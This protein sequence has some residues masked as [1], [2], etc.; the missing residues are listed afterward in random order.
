MLQKMQWDL[1]NKYEYF[2]NIDKVD[3]DSSEWAR[4]ILFLGEAGQLVQS[5]FGDLLYCGGFMGSVYN[6]K[7]GLFKFDIVDFYYHDLIQADQSNEKSMTQTD[8]LGRM[9]HLAVWDHKSNNLIVFGGQKGSADGY[10]ANNSQRTL[11]NDLVVFD[12]KR[13]QMVEHMVFSEAT[14]ERRMYHT[15]FKIDDSV[16]SIGGQG[17][18]GA[19]FNSFLEIKIRQR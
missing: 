10:G 4:I 5:G 16:F 2:Y 15:G 11:L 13:M 1:I 8:L 19:I 7:I 3:M 12:I 9:G 14:L 18:D 17:K 6:F